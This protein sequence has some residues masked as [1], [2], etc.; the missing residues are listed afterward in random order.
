MPRVS[1][2]EIGLHVSMDLLVEVILIMDTAGM[3]SGVIFIYTLNESRTGKVLRL[4]LQIKLGQDMINNL[5]FL[6]VDSLEYLVASDQV[7]D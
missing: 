5:R 3:E 4:D 7:Q 6:M 1:A 2:E